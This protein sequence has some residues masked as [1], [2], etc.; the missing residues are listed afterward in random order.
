[1]I[2]GFAY[3]AIPKVA[4]TACEKE[5]SQHCVNTRATQARAGTV[6]S[7]KNNRINSKILVSDW[8]SERLFWIE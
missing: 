7:K 4:G 1:M 8:F 2:T 3:T 6:Q 5:I